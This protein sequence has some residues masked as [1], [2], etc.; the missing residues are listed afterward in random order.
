MF[1]AKYPNG[2]V[3]TEKAKTWD[4]IKD[5]L[6]VLELT[7]P[8]PVSYVTKEGETKRAAARTVSLSGFDKYFFHNEAVAHMDVNSDNE[9]NN[10]QGVLVAQVIGG[11]RKGQVV[12]IRID[13][14][15]FTKTTIMDEEGFEHKDIK[16][17]G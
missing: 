15:G 16:N 4:K 8:I 5:G 13:K 9:L 17:A 10:G 12:M 11:I 7:F 3:V 2:E 14:G 1:I 6:T